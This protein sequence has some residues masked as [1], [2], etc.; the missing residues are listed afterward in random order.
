M[1]K[2]AV[3]M[4]STVKVNNKELPILS[5]REYKA[6]VLLGGMTIGESEGMKNLT[7]FYILYR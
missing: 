2:H 4:E 5:R 1:V 6:I 7:K 3:T